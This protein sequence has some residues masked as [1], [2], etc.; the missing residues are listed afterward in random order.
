MS[1]LFFIAVYL[2]DQV[3]GLSIGGFEVEV[4]ERFANTSAGDLY[5][6]SSTLFGIVRYYNAGDSLDSHFGVGVGICDVLGYNITQPTRL[7]KMI[8]RIK[9]VRYSRTEKES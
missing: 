5:M 6:P 9:Y 8:R 2:K 1:I 4:G 7:E 3:N